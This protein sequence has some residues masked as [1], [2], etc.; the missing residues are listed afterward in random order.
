MEVD[1]SGSGGTAEMIASFK[2]LFSAIQNVYQ[3]HTN[4]SHSFRRHKDEECDQ[5]MPSLAPFDINFASLRRSYSALFGS[6]TPV[7]AVVDELERR[8]DIAVNALCF[9][10]GFGFRI[11]PFI[12]KLKYNFE[13]LETIHILSILF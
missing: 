5:N 12:S 2:P 4:L 6:L 3:N 13:M 10:V 7:V 9:E 1:G 11:I 8:V